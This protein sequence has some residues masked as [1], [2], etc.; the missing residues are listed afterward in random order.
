MLLS[1]RFHVDF[2]QSPGS[3]MC[4][5]VLR[6]TSSL[7]EPINRTNVAVPDKKKTNSN[8]GVLAHQG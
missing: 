7:C 4:I 6:Y 3:F 2:A 8:P 1:E 5:L